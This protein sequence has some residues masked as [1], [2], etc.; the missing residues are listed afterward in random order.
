MENFNKPSELSF[1]GNVQRNWNQFKQ[2][3]NIY[4]LATDQSKKTDETKIA[5]LLNL[6]GDRAIEIFNQFTYETAGDEKKLDKVL[7]QFE[8]Y[9]SPRSNVVYERFVFFNTIQK[10]GQNFDNFLTELRGNA[11]SCKFKEEEDLIRDRIIFGVRDKGLQQRL[12]QR[13]N[14][15]GDQAATM[16]RAYEASLIQQQLM[17]SETS[18]QEAVHALGQHTKKKVTPD[19]Y[20]CKKCGKRHGPRQCPA[21][22]KVCAKCGNKNH[23]AVGCKVGN[24][25]NELKKGKRVIINKLKQLTSSRQTLKSV[26]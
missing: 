16:C 12:L 10:E 9:C 21:Y 19:H 7:D 24:R 22:G 13:E 3:F 23:Y 4:I 17:D 1:E 2:R 25:T 8:K 14:V 6:A 20:D 15:T 5:I 26:I 18:K 11:K